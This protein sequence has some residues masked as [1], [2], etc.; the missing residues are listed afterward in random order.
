MVT[1]LL[2]WLLLLASGADAPPT[3]PC[4][5]KRHRPGQTMGGAAR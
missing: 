3:N 1:L 5:G 2:V 4:P